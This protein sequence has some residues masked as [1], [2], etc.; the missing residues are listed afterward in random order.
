MSHTRDCIT[1]N[2]YPEMK[3]YKL[4]MRKVKKK[5]VCIITTSK[6]KSWNEKELGWYK[7]LDIAHFSQ[8]NMRPI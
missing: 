8:G 1:L 7:C 3:G 5:W 2:S 6:G 4:T